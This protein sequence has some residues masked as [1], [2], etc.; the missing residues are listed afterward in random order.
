VSWTHEWIG[1]NFVAATGFFPRTGY[2]SFGPFAN[3]RFYP[4]GTSIDRHGISF[5]FNSTLDPDWKQTDRHLFL[6]YGIDF[7][8]SSAVD[9]NFR[10]LYVKLFADFDPTRKSREDSTVVALPSGA[11]YRWREYSISYMSKSRKN[12]YVS[13]EVGVGGFYNGSGFDISGRIRYRVM[14]V[15]NL[16]FSYSYN[17]IRLPDPHPDAS[18]WLLGPRIDLTFT[19]KLYWTTYIQYHQQNDNVN[20]NSRLQWRF[21]P[22][23]DL[24]VVYTE[25]Y[26][27][28]GLTTKNRSVVMKISYWINL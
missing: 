15:F 27:P 1:E 9:L 4:S 23:S 5:Q 2:L 22:V 12:F 7:R 11:G 18:F 28:A 6:G 26:I 25:N 16:S 21:A 20:I 17:R 14:P 8:N 24:F 10:D 13:T 3:Y 19:D